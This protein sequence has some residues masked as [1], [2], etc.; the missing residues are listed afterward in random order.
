MKVLAKPGQE[1]SLEGCGAIFGR[2]RVEIN[3]NDVKLFL[4]LLIDLS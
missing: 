2:W 3:K 1:F 4:A